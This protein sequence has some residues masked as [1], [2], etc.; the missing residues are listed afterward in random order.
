MMPVDNG[1]AFQRRFPLRRC[2]M[3][4]QLLVDLRVK[5]RLW[6]AGLGG[7]NTFDVFLLEAS[8]WRPFGLTLLFSSFTT[9]SL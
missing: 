8:S 5:T 9:A 2:E 6:L 4:L 1:G 7:D 3:Y